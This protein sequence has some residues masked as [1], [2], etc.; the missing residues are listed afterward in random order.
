M[1]ATTPR[2]EK[3][4]APIIPR[5]P[6]LSAASSPISDL[7]GEPVTGLSFA[8]QASVRKCLQLIK[9]DESVYLSNQG[10]FCP[11][12]SFVPRPVSSVDRN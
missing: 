10:C 1:R 4:P 7:S 2:I 5:T 6:T 3:I 9:T 11:C 12:Q 8:G